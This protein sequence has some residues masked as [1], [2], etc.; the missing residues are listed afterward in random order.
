M[1]DDAIRLCITNLM[2]P[3]LHC[4]SVVRCQAYFPAV[5]HTV[6]LNVLKFNSTTIPHQDICGRRKVLQH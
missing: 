5:S 3:H 4:S 2:W 6:L 1:S